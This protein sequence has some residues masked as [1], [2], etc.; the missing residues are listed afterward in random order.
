[1]KRW[2]AAG[3]GGFLVS[4]AVA[5]PVLA[6]PAGPTDYRT[7][8][9]AVEPPTPAIEVAVIGGDSF[10][11]L[12]ATRGADVVV[13]GYQGEP[14]LWFRPDGAVLENRNAPSTYVNADRYGGGEIPPNASADAEPDWEQVG[15]GHRWAWHDHRI[16]W[17]QRSRPLGR[18][19][20]DQIL[21]A[22]VPLVVD[23]AEVDV[24]VISVWQPAPST[25]PM[26]L[27]VV[28]GAA[29]T[30]A[31]WVLRARRERMLLLV[32]PA[33]LALLVGVWQFRSLPSET[34]PRLV[35]WVLP[36]IAVACA[37]VAVV[38]ALRRRAFAARAAALL[39]GVELFGWGWIRRD[40]LTAAIIPS[41][42]PGW[43]DRLS[44]ALALTA[45]AGIAATMLWELFASGASR[46]SR[47]ARSS[48]AV[49]AGPLDASSAGGSAVPGG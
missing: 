32:G 21:E 28:A 4:L 9:V 35:W 25:V 38:A 39:V 34:G 42:A 13:M 44:V 36:A 11:E 49:P 16:H 17:M 26:W 14:Y 33:G 19:A 7:E 5:T 10:L 6:D 43:L 2:L 46:P 8:V 31:L 37:V 15:S 20:G 1:M 29:T 40:G 45:G 12:D 24:G 22:V 18:A 27:G 41:D 3:A 47:P 23:G 30:A 48:G